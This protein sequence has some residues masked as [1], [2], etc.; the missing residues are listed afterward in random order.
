MEMRLLPDFCLPDARGGQGG[1]EGLLGR[2][3]LLLALVHLPECEACAAVVEE[4]ARRVR[5][6]SIE[7][8]AVLALVS[9]EA[10]LSQYRTAPFAVVQDRDG[11]VCAAVAEAAGVQAGEPV[12]VS[13]ERYGRVQWTCRLIG[14]PRRVVDRALE[15]LRF[16]QVLSPESAAGAD[17]RE[18]L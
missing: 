1:T 3:K 6:S 10:D 14:D 9:G 2:H 8:A 17:E 13:V 12:L 5:S 7:G 4:L 15:A 11:T 18:G 16:A